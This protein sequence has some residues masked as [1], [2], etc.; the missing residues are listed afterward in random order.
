MHPSSQLDV[1][2]EE[3]TGCIDFAIKKIIDTVSEEL[4]AI[5]E[6]EQKDLASE[7]FDDEFDYLY[8][9]VTTVTKSNAHVTKSSELSI[10]TAP[11]ALSHISNFSG[12]PSRIGSDNISKAED[13]F[14]KMIREA[15]EENKTNDV[16]IFAYAHDFHF[17][18]LKV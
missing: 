14:D 9:I 4:I 13:D 3:V 15:F 7:G 6:G 10:S 17:I 2:G 1:E 11:I 16:K 18:V 5:T 8:G 12:D